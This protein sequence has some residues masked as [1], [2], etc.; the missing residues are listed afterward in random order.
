[1]PQQP[2]AVEAIDMSLVDEYRWAAN[3][4]RPGRSTCW[5][6][7]LLTEPLA[8]RHCEPRLFGH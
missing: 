5:G 7:P 4:C 2:V 3:T 1:M 8:V 6:N